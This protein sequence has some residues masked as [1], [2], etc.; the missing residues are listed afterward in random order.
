MT[1]A[2]FTRLLACFMRSEALTKCSQGGSTGPHIHCNSALQ[3]AQDGVT[4]VQE[5]F[6]YCRALLLTLALA[7]HMQSQRSRRWQGG[8]SGSQDIGKTLKKARRRR[9]RAVRP[10]ISFELLLWTFDNLICKHRDMNI[11]DQLLHVKLDR[12]P[13]GCCIAFVG[14]D[15]MLACVCL[16]DNADSFS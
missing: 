3:D 13:S 9:E 15:A 14:Q 2:D 6:L 11:P 5:A 4:L 8:L 1:L 10:Q 16:A 12:F 7:A